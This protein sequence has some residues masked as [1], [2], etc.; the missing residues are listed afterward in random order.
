MTEF[1][2]FL[3]ALAVA[4]AISRIAVDVRKIREYSDRMRETGL[5]GNVL[6]LREHFDRVDHLYAEARSE[7]VDET[8]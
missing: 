5:S 3:I 7:K 8:T 2:A 4:L 1:F 6:A